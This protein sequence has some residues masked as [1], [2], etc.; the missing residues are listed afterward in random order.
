MLGMDSTGGISDGCSGGSWCR[1]KIKLHIHRQNLTLTL[2][3]TAGGTPISPCLSPC[4]KSEV[5]SRGNPS[6]MMR[7][8]RIERSVP[9]P[10]FSTLSPSCFGHEIHPTRWGLQKTNI[11][12]TSPFTITKSKCQQSNNQVDDKL[13]SSKGK[14]PSRPL[15]TI[16]LS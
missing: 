3:A 1:R 10:K 16:R 6:K 9:S 14:R 2:T 13:V 12:S 8:S 5:W 15:K 4:L 7:T 11:T